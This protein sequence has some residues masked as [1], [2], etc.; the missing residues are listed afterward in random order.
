MSTPVSLTLF[1]LPYSGASA[2]FYSPW[3]RKL[4]EWLNIRPLELPGRGMRM[5]EPLQTD[6]VQLAS[7]LAD[8]I[9]ADLDKPYGLFGH[10]LGGLL[11]FELAHALRERG[12]PAPLALFASATAG[13]VRRD[14]S[15]YAQ[16]KTDEQLIARL[17][18]LKGTSENVIANDEL[19]Q[20]MLPI[21]RADFLLCGS[22]VYGQREPL[23][24]PIH[25]FG[26]KQDSVSVEQLLDWQEETCTGFSLDMFEGHHFYLVDEQIQLLRHLRRYCE[27]HLARWR[28]S[29][30]RQLNR[31][32]G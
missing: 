18:T 7:H 21:L 5:D 2:M 8:E 19:M 11:A 12:L 27:L 29:T 4:P 24:L 28:N 6:I 32:T 1:C 25:V 9:S 17:R 3:R 22:F 13:P 10:S 20:L 26:G 31:A 15:E 23:N 14:V 16:A 30:S